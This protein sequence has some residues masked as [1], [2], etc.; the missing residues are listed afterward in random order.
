M[1][2][3]A[4]HAR[5]RRWKHR[6]LTSRRVR[7]DGSHLAARTLSRE[8]VWN[9][10]NGHFRGRLVDASTGGATSDAIVHMPLSPAFSAG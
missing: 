8:Q 3:G 4:V 5:C 7:A 1:I 10:C 9:D 6:R 2:D